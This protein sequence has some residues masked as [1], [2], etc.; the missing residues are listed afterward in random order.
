MD[1]TRE[2]GYLKAARY[3]QTTEGKCFQVL[4]IKYML[5]LTDTNWVFIIFTRT[6]AVV[7]RNIQSY[8]HLAWG[9][10][11]LKYEPRFS[12][13][14]LY[15]WPVQHLHYKTN[16]LGRHKKGWK[17]DGIPRHDTRTKAEK[18]W[19][20]TSR[21]SSAEKTQKE[22]VT[23]ALSG[24]GTGRQPY[25]LLLLVSSCTSILIFLSDT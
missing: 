9:E 7:L 8:V 25:S 2:L 11:A 15:D 17:M 21:L 23:A 6:A 18:C 4:C 13:F 19:T 14:G 24:L 22:I 20:T 1:W 12:S 3:P 16:Y 5:S 10:D